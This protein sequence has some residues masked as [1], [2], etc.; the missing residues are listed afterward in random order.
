MI[1]AAEMGA[2][3]ARNLNIIERQTAGLT[4]ADSLLQPP[5]RGNCLNRVLGH[6]LVYRDETLK[7][8]GAAPLW[9]PERSAPCLNGS[10]PLTDGAQAVALA[11][12]LADLR[13]SQARLEAALGALG[14]AQLQ[15]PGVAWAANLREALSEMVWH[16][17]YH[18]GQ[19]G[20]LRQ[21]SGVNDK[22]L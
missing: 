18:T 8:A 15:G 4:H 1:T 14:E 17:S 13:R 21:L 12:I 2:M 7:M 5:F 19:T 6:I 22:V 11:V 16:D 10:E 9:G 20:Y 3:L